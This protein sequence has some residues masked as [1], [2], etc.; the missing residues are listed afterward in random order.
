MDRKTIDYKLLKAAPQKLRSLGLDER[1]LQS[2]IDEDPALLG[3]G[4]LQ[5]L[6]RERRQ[7]A[8]GRIDFLLKDPEEDTRYEVE[9]MLGPLDESH[10]IRTIEYWDIERQRYPSYEHRAVII[11]EEITARFFNVVRLLNR[12]VP[13]I[14]IQLS[15]FAFED[16]VVLHFT[17]VLDIYEEAESE[18]EAGGEKVDR[19]NWVK[20]SSADSIASLDKVIDLAEQALGPVRVTYNKHH[21]AMNAGS[22]NFAWFYPRKEAAYCPMELWMGTDIRDELM[23]DLQKAGVPASSRK[24]DG[25]VLRLTASEV[26]KHRALLLDVFKKTANASR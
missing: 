8:G 18:D 26:E 4:D 10:I 17:K 19:A 11:A 23:G 6:H 1:W 21:V 7:A 20:R 16:Q 14:A 12:A 3:L 9:V 15:A 24:S 25:L 13:L 5:V 22:T 2:K